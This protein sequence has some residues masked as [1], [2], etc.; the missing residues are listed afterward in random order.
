MKLAHLIGA[1]A[2]L[3][4]CSGAF[5]QTD[6]YV[7]YSDNP[8]E[9]WIIQGG[10]ITDHWSHGTNQLAPAVRDT[11]RTIRW[12]HGGNGEE[13]TFNGTLTGNVLLDPGG[14][15]QILDGAANGD[16]NFY[17]EWNGGGTVYRTNA[18]WSQ[19][20]SL[21]STGQ[22]YTGITFD[23]ASQTLWLVTD[24]GPVENRNLEGDLLSSFDL[25]F[26]RWGA[27]A[28]EAST[29]S[30]WMTS[31]TTSEIRQYDKNGGLLGSMILE[32]FGNVWGGEMPVPAPAS[33]ALLGLAGL[34][35]T[36]RR[37]LG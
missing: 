24:Q 3:A 26:G 2:I 7:I 36:R 37:R 15:G 8:D 21:F 1:S 28:Y 12:D 23:L 20:A 5:A 22:S 19:P 27:L 18:D 29:D 32:D 31:N 33:A 30:L 34:T 13:R 6:P 25:P 11:I 10:F 16:S 17:A 4:I 9:A 14:I 35:M